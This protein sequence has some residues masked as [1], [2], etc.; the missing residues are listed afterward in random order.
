[1]EKLILIFLALLLD[2]CSV[3]IKKM[4]LIWLNNGGGIL[5]SSSDWITVVISTP[6]LPKSIVCK[7]REGYVYYPGTA[8]RFSGLWFPV[9]THLSITLIQ[10]NVFRKDESAIIAASINSTDVGYYGARID[11]TQ[12]RYGMDISLNYMGIGLTLDLDNYVQ[13]ADYYLLL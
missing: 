12:F 2:I 7:E 3:P 13:I 11:L 8:R 5:S 10:H 6:N 9:S 1:M 4:S